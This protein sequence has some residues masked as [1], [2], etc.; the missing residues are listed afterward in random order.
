MSSEA[1]SGAAREPK[2][3]RG[4][5]RVAALLDAAAAVFTEKGFDA[6]TMTEIAARAGAPIGSL[7]QF[8]P[9]KEVLADILVR[10][11]ADVLAADLQ[12][13]EERAAAL[14]TPELVETM[15]GLLMENHSQERAVAM[16][17]V[18]T[19]DPSARHTTFR[20][21]LRRRIAAVLRVHAPTLDADAA[22]DTAVVLLQL[23]K[24]MAALNDETALTAR[25]AVVRELR[26]LAVLYVERRLRAG[27]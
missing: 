7:Y 1:E 12:D 22:R 6:A 19:M 11:Y 26:E 16:A 23:M 5:Q 15:T 4:K 27:R 8:F 17:L 14:T 24:G 18:D 25:A 9:S 13:L 21:M 2:R 10:R 20:Q 3:E